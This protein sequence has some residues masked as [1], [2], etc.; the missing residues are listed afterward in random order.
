MFNGASTVYTENMVTSP[1][2]TT[3]IVED[4]DNFY[5]EFGGD[6]EFIVDI[7]ISLQ[8]VFS[9]E[10]IPTEQVNG[11]CEL[12]A[13]GVDTTTTVIRGMGLNISLVCLYLRLQ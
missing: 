13:G 10:P 2:E 7:T 3:F 5:I 8:E 12:N 6:P 9:G 4:A 1:I 11:Y